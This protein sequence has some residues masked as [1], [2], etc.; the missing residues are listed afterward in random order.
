MYKLI[1]T[2]I[3]I[4]V[5]I[6][7]AS[8][9]QL[10][11]NTPTIDP[12]TSTPIPS[13][14]DPVATPAVPPPASRGLSV[15]Y[16][17]VSLTLPEKLASGI[18]GSQIP[19]ADSSDL[20]VWGKTPGHIQIQLE[21]YPQEGKTQQPQIYVY[22]AMDYVNLN[23]GTFE[24]IHRLDNI[25]AAPGAAI[26]V[27]QLP[28]VPF[29]NAKQ[30]FGAYIQTIPF[31]NGKGVRYLTQYAQGLMPIDNQSLVYTYQGL[32]NDGADYIVV[33]LPVSLDS[34]TTFENWNGQQPA[35]PSDYTQYV[36]DVVRWLNQQQ[37][38]EYIPDLSKL[39]ALIQSIAIQ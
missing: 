9:S 29:L 20:P 26:S 13:G 27:D 16:E 32:T 25:F 38:S 37:P 24:S 7:L 12:P 15:T 2:L 34:L 22:P 3:L 5:I 36:T 35:S 31:Q 17:T 19:R 21:G 1:T 14:A 18:N 10:A 6:A 33:I 28:E 30:T 11:T 8:C 23:T 4:G 39:D